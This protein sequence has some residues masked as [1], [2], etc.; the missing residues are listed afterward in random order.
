MIDEHV[1]ILTAAN[2]KVTVA[3]WTRIRVFF[4]LFA[5]DNCCALWTL[6]PQSVRHLP[7]LLLRGDVSVFSKEPCHVQK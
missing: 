1:Y 5:V 2:A 4:E 3:F 7:K 6:R